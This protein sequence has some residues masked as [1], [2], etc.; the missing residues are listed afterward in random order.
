M[1]SIIAYSHEYADESRLRDQKRQE[2][3][4]RR[5]GGWRLRGAWWCCP[6]C[7]ACRS[8][9]TGCVCEE[10]CDFWVDL[11]C[12][13]ELI[14]CERSFITLCLGLLISG[15]KGALQP[16]RVRR[17][18]KEQAA[19]SFSGSAAPAGKGEKDLSVSKLLPNLARPCRRR[20]RNLPF[21]LLTQH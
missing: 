14:C 19:F 10:I 3:V 16:P 21:S 2:S 13:F 12:N 15:H 5:G 11:S 17:H 4:H 20:R 7:G 18:C 6:S 9:P 1:K 8:R